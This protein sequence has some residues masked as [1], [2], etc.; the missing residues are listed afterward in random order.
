MESISPK[1][2]AS[3]DVIIGQIRVQVL[4]SS[5]V[6][7]ELKGAKGFED[8]NTFHV[9]DRNWPGTPYASNLVAG[10]VVINTAQYA[11]HVPQAAASLNG[12]YVTSPAGSVLYRFDGTLTSS[13]WLPGPADNPMVFPLADAP[14]LIP[15]P[16]GLVPAPAGTPPGLDQRLGT[17]TMMRQ[18]FMCS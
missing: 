13:A 6:R 1:L 10:E 14:R 9:V 3:D 17:P 18:M 16:G 12:T 8:R 15:P 4:S 2:L 11:V 5:L 7:L